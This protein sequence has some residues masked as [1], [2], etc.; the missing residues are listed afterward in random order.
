[1]NGSSLSPE[2]EAKLLNLIR[3]STSVQT[4]LKPEKLPDRLQALRSSAFIRRQQRPLFGIRVVLFDIYGTLFS[5]RAGDIGTDGAVSRFAPSGS[6]DAQAESYFQR[7]VFERHLELFAETPYPEVQVDEIWASYP[8]R[9]QDITSF[10]YAL[11][12]ELDH[13]P[14][15]PMPGALDCI[16]Q[17]REAGLSLGIVSNAQ[18]YT[19]LVF[20]AF[21]GAAPEQLGFSEDLIAYSYRFGRAK[22]A[23]EL[24]EPVLSSLKKQG[25]QIDECLY[26]GNDMLN[27]VYGAKNVGMRAALFAGDRNSLRLREDN[28]LC[29]DLLPDLVLESLSDL[30]ACLSPAL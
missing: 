2:L 20:K 26:V 15:F 13:N 5:S 29:K 1:M 8:G 19:P 14:A 21:F 10:E 28:P 23:P 3:R 16:R 25:Y 22:P 12:Y 24:F 27:D 7:A 30:P 11:R 9:P 6:G 17:L 4:V 18:F